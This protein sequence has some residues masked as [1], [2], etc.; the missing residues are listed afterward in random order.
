MTQPPP[1]QRF[2][3]EPLLGEPDLPRLPMHVAGAPHAPLADEWFETEEPF[4]GT[5]WARVAGPRTST[6]PSGRR[7][8][9]SRAGAGP[10]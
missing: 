9:R 10:R 4:W 6:W 1:A 2:D 7:T 8:L 5:A 3:D